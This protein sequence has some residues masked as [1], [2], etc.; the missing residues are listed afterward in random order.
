[1]GAP[2]ADAKRAV[3]LRELLN[4][5]SYE[6]HVLDTPSVDDAEYDTLLRELQTLEER[7]PELRTPDSPT[8]RVGAAPSS[9]FAPSLSAVVM[10]LVR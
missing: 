5:Y 3:R 4:R 1:M 2:A 9:A 8:S 10:A 6:Y 7:N